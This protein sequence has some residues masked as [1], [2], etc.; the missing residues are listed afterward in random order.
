MPYVQNSWRMK[1]SIKWLSFAMCFVG[2]HVWIVSVSMKKKIACMR[3]SL[4]SKFYAE[5]TRRSKDQQHDSEGGTWKNPF[6]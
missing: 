2:W 1:P 3:C 4:K 5:Y 6:R